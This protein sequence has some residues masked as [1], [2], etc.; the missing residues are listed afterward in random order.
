MAIAIICL[1]ISICL[2]VGGQLLLKLS[3]SEELPALPIIGIF[4]FPFV[5]A[6]GLYFISLLFYTF[7]LKTLPLQ[8]AF[9]SVSLSY[10]AVAWCSHQIWGTSFG[11]KEIAA[12]I[13]ITIAIALL[14]PATGS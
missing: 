5:A 12:F 11:I 2:G 1:G 9:P 3:V 4:N 6:A 13:L 10:V 7:S 14:V 8:L